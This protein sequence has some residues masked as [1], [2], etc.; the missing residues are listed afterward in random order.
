MDIHT[1]SGHRATDKCTQ[2]IKNAEAIT[3]IT[4]TGYIQLNVS[5]RML[6]FTCER[7]LD[8]VRVKFNLSIP[9]VFRHATKHLRQNTE[10]YP[11]YIMSYFQYYL[12]TFHQAYFLSF[13][14]GELVSPCTT[15]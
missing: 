2:Q 7:T 15:K 8:P 12:K 5:K 13:L 1:W 3:L 9:S 11:F 10:S 14:Y 6:F 4:Y